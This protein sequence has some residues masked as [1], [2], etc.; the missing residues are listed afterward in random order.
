MDVSFAATILHLDLFE[1]PQSSGVIDWR[2]AAMKM[3]SSGIS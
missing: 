1:G 2:R 3:R